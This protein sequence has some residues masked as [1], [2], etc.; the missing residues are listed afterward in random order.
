ML[1]TFV[2]VGDVN[3]VE[4][5]VVDDKGGGGIVYVADIL[6]SSIFFIAV[7]DG[8]VIVGP[9]IVYVAVICSSVFLIEELTVGV[10]NIC[11]EFSDV[12]AG[13]LSL[14]VVVVDASVVVVA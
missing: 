1:N 12:V 7:I 3:E 11:A 5:G 2:L 8:V 9:L 14:I 10:S 6:S 4:C 13:T